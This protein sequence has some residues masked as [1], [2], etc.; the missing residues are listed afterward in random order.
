MLKSIFVKSLHISS[1]FH[2]LPNSGGRIDHGHHDAH[3]LYAIDETLEFH[4][5]IDLTKQRTNEDNTLIVVT[6][7]HSHT[8]SISGYSVRIFYNNS[9]SS[10][11]ACPSIVADR[12]MTL[13]S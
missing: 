8:M 1:L 11:V 4:K 5:A 13:L 7:D 12:I 6:S 3:A 10:I 2:P 9:L